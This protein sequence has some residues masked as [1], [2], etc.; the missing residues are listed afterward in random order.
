M[1]PGAWPR[2]GVSGYTTDP[3]ATALVDEG[4]PMDREL[5]RRYFMMKIITPHVA[6]YAIR[7]HAVSRE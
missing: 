1:A 6:D 7:G 3:G 4:I 5:T 2:G